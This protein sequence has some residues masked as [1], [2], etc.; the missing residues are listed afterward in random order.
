LYFNIKPVFI[1]AKLSYSK[2]TITNVSFGKVERKRLSNHHYEYRRE[3]EMS[4][5]AI[6][7]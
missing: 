2:H 3:R 5:I 1:S 7:D 6:T 4:G